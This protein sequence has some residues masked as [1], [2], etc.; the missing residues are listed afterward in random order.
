[1]FVPKALIRDNTVQALWSMARDKSSTVA[2]IF[3]NGS[4]AILDLEMARV[5]NEEMNGKMKSMTQSS[6]PA[7]DLMN[8]SQ[9]LDVPATRAETAEGFHHEFCRCHQRQ[10]ATP[11]RVPQHSQIMTHV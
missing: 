7:L 6:E 11:D 9:K 3:K 10:W 5:R 8:I 1:M 2:V 4:C